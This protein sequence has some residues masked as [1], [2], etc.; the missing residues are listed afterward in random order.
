MVRAEISR[1]LNSFKHFDIIWKWHNKSH[2]K[3]RY[4][5]LSQNISITKMIKI[6]NEE[7]TLSFTFQTKLVKGQS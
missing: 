7:P 2:K 1:K 3:R 4:F 6:R 5:D